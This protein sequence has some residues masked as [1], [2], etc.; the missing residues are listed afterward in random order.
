[1]ADEANDSGSVGTDPKRLNVQLYAA[2][3]CWL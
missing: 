3:R 1:M 2:D